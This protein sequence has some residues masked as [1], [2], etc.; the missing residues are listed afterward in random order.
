MLY[1]LGR[2]CTDSGQLE[3][4]PH[5]FAARV[6]RAGPPQREPGEAIDRVFSYRF[7]DLLRACRSGRIIDS[8]TLATVLRLEPHFDGDRFAFRP[9]AG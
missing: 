6:I 8:M 2:I 5:L 1:P 7:T 3:G 4:V 9:D